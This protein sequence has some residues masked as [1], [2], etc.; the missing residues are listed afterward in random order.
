M[1]AYFNFKQEPVGTE[2]S[3]RRWMTYSRNKELRTHEPLKSRF[4]IMKWMVHYTGL[5]DACSIRFRELLIYTSV[6]SD[7][8]RCFKIEIKYIL[9]REESLY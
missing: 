3:P 5:L 7:V 1:G 8:L 9:F 2:R 4:E 6:L